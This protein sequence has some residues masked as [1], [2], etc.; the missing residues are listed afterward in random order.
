[1]S[2]YS[3]IPIIECGEKLV[4]IPDTFAFTNPHVYMSLGA[5][6]GDLSPFY[7]RAGVLERLD[8]ALINLQTNL[9][10]QCPNWRI[11]IFDAYRPVAVQ[12]FMVNYTK[13]QLAQELNL[14]ISDRIQEQELM[15][16]VYKFWAVPSLD[17]A[18]PPPHSTGAAIDV[19]LVDGNDCEVDMGGDIDE[20][21]D[22][23]HPNYYQLAQDPEKKRFHHNRYLLSNC[24]TSAGFQQH[25]NEWW[26]FSYGDQMWCYLGKLNIE[27]SA[28]AYYGRV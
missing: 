6:Y 9:Q 3:D 16:K 19:T 11:K 20:I 23:S 21:S 24:M 26:H 18:T 15:Q 14:D 27:N 17:P 5:T 8:L 12:E 2:F 7:I 1:M 10:I 22:R 4:N 13:L 25:P 28:I